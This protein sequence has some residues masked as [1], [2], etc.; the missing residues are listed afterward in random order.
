MW[1]L[2]FLEEGVEF[3]SKMYNFKIFLHLQDQVRWGYLEA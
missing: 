3:L 2:F 1:G